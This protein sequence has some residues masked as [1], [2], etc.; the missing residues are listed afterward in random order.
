MENMA[1]KF[2]S[3]TGAKEHNLKNVSIDLP[4]DEL[5]VVTGISGSGKSS[6]AF[7]TVYA[8]GQRRYEILELPEE[9]KIYLLAPIVRGGKGE[10]TRELLNLKKDGYTRI[11]IDGE[12]H[13]LDEIPVIDKNKKHN[14]EVVVDRLKVDD[15]LG[16][17]LPSSIETVLG[18]SKGLL[19]VE[20]VE[21]PKSYKGDHKNGDVIV[22]SEKFACPESGFQLTEIEPRM[23]SFNSPYGACEVCDGLGTEGFYDPELVVPNRTLSINEG[24]VAPWANSNNKMYNQT[25]L[26]LAEHMDFDLD[27]M[28]SELPENVQQTILYGSGDVEITFEYDDGLR[29]YKV[30]QP[31]EGVI[32]NMQR[33]VD[34]ADTFHLRSS[35]ETYEGV[36]NCSACEGHR[37]RP[38]SLCIKIAD[39]H[40]GN[41][42][43]KTIDECLDWFAELPKHLNKTHN[44]IAERILKEIRMRLQ[45]LNDVGL[46]YLTLNRKSGTLSGGESQRIRLASQI[47]S[48]LSGVLYVLD[49]PSIGLHQRDNDKLIQTLKNLRDLGNTVIVVEHDE[50]TMRNADY[51]ID[52]GP[53]AGIHGGEI[54]SK[55]TPSEV[56]N[57]P[58][59]L[60]GQY[61][62]G[63]KEIAK[64]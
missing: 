9:T 57:D 10:H 28:F 50:D 17:R 16:N 58:K 33:R 2:I 24:A 62:S 51:L 34:E 11:K 40:I 38:E 31:F 6:L 59:S 52:V 27:E 46:N 15:E 54:V 19:Q 36:T 48:G 60:T 30:S 39:H 42:S 5:I 13:S 41:V 21:L 64:C 12:I 56:A 1:E 37:L 44:Q 20:I 49:E 8:E 32:P 55:G 3:V 4:K 43:A 18:L 26:A 63:K 25:L 29:T 22:F 23:F 53:G 61:L 7:D 35:F 14:M 45:F 47:G